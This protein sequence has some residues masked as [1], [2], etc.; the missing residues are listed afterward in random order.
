MGEGRILHAAF[1]EDKMLT[2]RLSWVNNIDSI[3]HTYGV[4]LHT[5]AHS[6]FAMRSNALMVISILC[7]EVFHFPNANLDGST[8]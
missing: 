7:S 6:T 8:K 3:L 2:P 5:Y 1:E 4:N